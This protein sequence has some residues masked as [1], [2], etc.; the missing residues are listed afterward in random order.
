MKIACLSGKGGA[1]KT[2]VA[3]NLATIADGATYIDCDV[4]EPNG[5]LFLTPDAGS[6]ETDVV[7]TLLP[8]FDASKC[9]GCKAC[10]R[11]CRFHAL[12]YIADKPLVFPEICH[13]CG[14]C[15]MICPNGAVSEVPKP[16]G[17]I[18]LAQHGSTKIVTGELNTGEATGVPVI[19]AALEHAADLTVID[20]PPGSACP[21]MESI[22]DADYCVLVA[23]PTAFGFHNFK[24]VH[25]LVTLLDRKCGVVINKQDAPYEPLEDYCA[26][27]GVSVLARIPYDARIASLVADG[28]IATEHDNAIRA[29]FTELL[30]EIEAQA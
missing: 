24:M 3:V 9:D 14:G 11:F 17:L 15:K 21:V 4:E 10:V 18:E 26:A 8:S 1:G 5:R 23:E 19:K 13:S 30:A 22:E 28:L 7:S 2:F 12:A 25:E 20:C 6:V 16:I 27:K 29:L